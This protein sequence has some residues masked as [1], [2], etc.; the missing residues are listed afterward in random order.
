MTGGTTVLMAL[1]AWRVGIGGRSAAGCGVYRSVCRV[2][3]QVYP[4]VTA[5]AADVADSGAREEG[6]VEG[7]HRGLQK[8]AGGGRGR[9]LSGGEARA[10]GERMLDDLEQASTTHLIIADREG[11]V[12]CDAVAGVPLRGGSGWRRGRGSC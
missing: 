4:V 9:S 3:E 5:A 12:V 1:K 7:E 2:M 8:R 11:N 10:D 6:G